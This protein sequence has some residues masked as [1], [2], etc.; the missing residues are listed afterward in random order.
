MR[1]ARL[2]GRL[3]ESKLGL[4]AV[5]VFAGLAFHDRKNDGVVFPR[6]TT[7]AEL[8]GLSVNSVRKALQ[9]LAAAGWI[10]IRERDRKGSVSSAEY[11]LNY[12][13]FAVSRH[14]TATVSP[15]DMVAVSPRDMDKAPTVSSSDTATVSKSEV[16]PYHPVT[17]NKKKE[18]DREKDGDDDPCLA[19]RLLSEVC[20]NFNMKFQS[21]RGLQ[22]KAEAAKRGTTARAVANLMITQ[23]ELYNSS[24]GRLSYTV[25]SAEKFWSSGTWHDSGL[26]P[27]EKAAAPAGSQPGGAR[28]P[29][30]AQQQAEEYLQAKAMNPGRAANA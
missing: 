2:P 4:H 24:R 20:G 17:R 29:S 12:N 21:D 14:D 9:I 18:E 11:Q 23:W 27:W 22:I 6:L 3:I 15:G 19:S 25:S 26:W 7:L 28:K 5:V 13:H 8:V 16:S 1:F 30:G 10:E